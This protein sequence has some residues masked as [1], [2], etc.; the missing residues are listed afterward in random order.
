[1]DLEEVKSIDFNSF[2]GD[3]HNLLV[4]IPNLIQRNWPRR[5][6]HI[7]SSRTIFKARFEVAVTTYNAVLSLCSETPDI[8]VR[9]FLPLATAPLVRNLFEELITLIFLLNDVPSYLHLLALSGYREKADEIA[10]YEN[11]RPK[12]VRGMSI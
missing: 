4:A 8:P 9:K 2:S 7:D 10:H 6:W 5:Y 11:I 1:M 3:L 12:V